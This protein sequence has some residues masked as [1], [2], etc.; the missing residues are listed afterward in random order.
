MHTIDKSISP[1]TQLGVVLVVSSLTRPQVSRYHFF[2]HWKQLHHPSS[3]AL[4]QCL[5]QYPPHHHPT[6]TSTT[7]YA[8]SMIGRNSRAMA[9]TNVWVRRRQ[10]VVGMEEGRGRKMLRCCG[11]QELRM[12]L[13]LGSSYFF[14]KLFLA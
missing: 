11:S 13:F 8:E 6:T 12:P 14:S 9:K 5:Q 2:V 1:H 4:G 10:S 3:V 7:C